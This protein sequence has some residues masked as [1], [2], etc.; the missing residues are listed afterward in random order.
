MTIEPIWIFILISRLANNSSTQRA[1]LK[2]RMIE[3]SSA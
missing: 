3:Q 2:S 1:F